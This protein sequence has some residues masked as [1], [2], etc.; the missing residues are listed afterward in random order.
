MRP[1]LLRYSGAA[2]FRDRIYALSVSCSSDCIAEDAINAAAC[3]GA[4]DAMLEREPSSVEAMLLDGA[5]FLVR[6]TPLKGLTRDHERL[7]DEA[8]LLRLSGERFSVSRVP[9][10]EQR[11]EEG[12]PA[13]NRFRPFSSIDELPDDLSL[14]LDHVVRFASGNAMRSL[15]M[16]PSSREEHRPEPEYRR[17]A[18]SKGWPGFSS[19]LHEA[20]IRKAEELTAAARDTQEMAQAAL[21]AGD[22]LQERASPAVSARETMELWPLGKAPAKT[23]R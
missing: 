16:G 13:R 18:R 12:I 6:F 22:S 23:G 5:D 21:P 14:D 19:P 20:I 7:C 1:R 4:K 9:V 17:W 10:Q 15:V 8:F 2:L 3:A 11:A